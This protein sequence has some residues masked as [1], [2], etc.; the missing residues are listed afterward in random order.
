MSEYYAKSLVEHGTGDQSPHGNRSG[1]QRNRGGRGSVRT[2]EWTHDK[3]A[4]VKWWKRSKA[5]GDARRQAEKMMSMHRALK[6][7]NAVVAGK[8]AGIRPSERA[9]NIRFD[10]GMT[11]GA[12]KM[13]KT[14]KPLS[15]QYPDTQRRA[16]LTLYKYRKMGGK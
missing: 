1:G 8:P 7:T 15:S 3:G 6:R 14:W 16:K 11:K 4:P 5:A 12:L 13:Q 10:L 9:H 2:P